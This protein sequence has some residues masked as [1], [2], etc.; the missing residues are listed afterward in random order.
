[1]QLEPIEVEALRENWYGVSLRIKA[2]G[3]WV[4]KQQ[5]LKA[6]M[7]VKASRRL[8]AVLTS[9]FSLQK[10]KRADW[11]SFFVG[12]PGSGQRKTLKMC[13]WKFLAG[14]CCG[15]CGLNL[16]P[17][18]PRT[19]CVCVCVWTEMGGVQLSLCWTY[20]K[21]KKR[22][23]T[24][25]LPVDTLQAFFLSSATRLE[26]PK[27]LTR[28]LGSYQIIWLQPVYTC[29]LLICGNGILPARHRCATHS[30]RGGALCTALVTRTS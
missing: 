27:T 11:S 21:D 20:V 29:E 17:L 7:E 12:G 30:Q 18:S 26:F 1:M 14:V 13:P 28:L 25:L 8:L 2:S 10:N 15:I 19:V 16:W 9:N 3:S 6:Q 5:L 23:I 24:P 4:F 22:K